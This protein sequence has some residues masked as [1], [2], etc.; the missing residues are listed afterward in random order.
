LIRISISELIS[1][2]IVEWFGDKWKRIHH[3]AIGH[4]VLMAGHRGAAARIQV[5]AGTI[6]L[7]VLRHN[8]SGMAK[9][10]VGDSVQRVDLRNQIEDFDFV[11]P[12]SCPAGSPSEVEVTVDSD[13]ETPSSQSQVWILGF[14]FDRV[15]PD[16]TK[17]K[18]LS[19]TTRLI[20]G[21]W[22]HFLVLNNDQVIPTEILNQ[23]A[24]GPADIE[25]FKRHIS[26]GDCV[27]DIGAHVGH[28]TIVFSRLVGQA[29]LVLSVEAQR[30]MFQ[31]MNA[32]CIINGAFNVR[33]FHAAASD[34]QQIV[35]LHPTNYAR[36]DNFGSLG[37]N[38]KPERSPPEKQG[39]SVAAVCV[40][41]LVEQQC[42]DRRVAFIKIDVQAYEKYALR[43]LLRTITRCKPKIFLEISPYWMFKAGYDY[44]DIYHFLSSLGYKFDHFIK[45]DLGTDGLPDYD[46]EFLGE[47]DTLAYP[48][49]NASARLR[50]S[51]CSSPHGESAKS[52]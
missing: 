37:V 46:S 16:R 52:G 29:G 2:G 49:L 14:T 51:E 15:P 34:H 45:L 33:P 39:E 28:H 11:I 30:V 47:W 31:L 36:L 38:P 17:S 18:T 19:S 21:D 42:E 22:G 5:P 25:L 3:Q 23:G 32:N 50:Q 44:R 4:T 35:S 7:W 41:D 27:L 1:N 12:L 6:G 8:W 9:V 26:T 43:G 48:V 13:E 10:Q 24:W 20:E 40:D